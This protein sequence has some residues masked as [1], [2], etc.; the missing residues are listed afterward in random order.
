MGKAFVEPPTLDIAKC[1]EDSRTNLPL[2]FVLSS[3]SDPME[4]FNRFAESVG[5]GGNKYSNISLG[6]GQGKKAEVMIR[7]AT[8]KGTWALLQNCDLSV[9]WLPRLEEICETVLQEGVKSDFR[10]WLTSKPHPKFPLS[11]IQNSV[12]MTMEP[13]QGLKKNLEKTYNALDDS[14]LNQCR[15]KPSE[16]KK[17]C[18]CFSFFHAVI[19]DR[20]KFGPIGWNKHYPFT[21]ED[22]MTSLKQLTPILDLYEKIPFNVINYLGGVINYG[23]RVTDDKDKRLIE[24]ILAQY[25]KIEALREGFKLC[26]GSDIYRQVEAE[27]QEDYLEYI[28]TLPLNPE[29]EVFGLHPNAEISTA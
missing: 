13:P 23:G 24:T 9:S 18:F 17:L 25:I 6:Q 21:D 26:K 22:L 7:D 5:M 3:G 28:E 14:R 19:L 27:N 16:F 20:R 11:I 29:P 10:L 15:S 8:Q 4:L 2:L 1:F 12:K